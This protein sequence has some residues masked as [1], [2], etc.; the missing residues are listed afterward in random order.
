MFDRKVLKERAKAAFKANYWASVLAA[1]V[2]VTLPSALMGAGSAFSSGGTAATQTTATMDAQTE[3]AVATFNSLTPEQQ[4]AAVA[5]VGA[6]LGGALVIGFIVTIL[7]AIFVANPL[8]LGGSRFFMVN[9]A[10]PA[11]TGELGYGFKPNYKK[12]V[13]IM[14]GMFIRIFLWSLLFIIPGI[15][16]AFQYRM[17][18][19]LLAEDDS[20]EMKEYLAASSY[21]M[22][23]N[24]WKAFVLDLSFIGWHLL[25]A[26][27]F[28]LVELFY[29]APYH[30]AANAELYVELKN[31]AVPA[32]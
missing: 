5:A 8:S 6:V 23:G 4:T 25:G 1:L 27:T 9:T 2:G 31:Q 13:K 22:D 29:A 24:K 11:K 19:Y 21:M 10:E 15:I 32:A 20:M 18:P 16:K 30:A 14:F 7:M 17:I 3:Q 12:K 28:G 26:L